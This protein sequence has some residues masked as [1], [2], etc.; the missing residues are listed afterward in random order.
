MC[1]LR[2]RGKTALLDAMGKTIT[3][4]INKK[5]SDA[6]CF[7]SCII[8]VSTDG[9]ENASVLYNYDNI[10]NLIM[11]AKKHGI[12]LLYLAANQ[13]AIL[14]ASKFGLD[15][16]NALNYSET[17]ENTLAAYRSASA[18]AKRRRLNEPC[19]FL[20][21]ERSDSVSQL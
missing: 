20:P 10:K 9:V 21:S 13:D 8:Y 16:N 12:E 15:S 2:P 3:Y 7:E 18:L 6:N 11:N 17:P 14:E 1:D 5:L 4:F 19:Y